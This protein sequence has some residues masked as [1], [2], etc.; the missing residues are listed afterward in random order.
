MI[1]YGCLS[2]E[3]RIYNMLIDEN[4]L[5]KEQL[6]NKD[7]QIKFLTQLIENIWREKHD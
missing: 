4:E 6:K 3:D 2:L 7:E 1:D 5:L